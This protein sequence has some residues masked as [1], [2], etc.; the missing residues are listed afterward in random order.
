M[1]LTFTAFGETVEGEIESAVQRCRQ[2]LAFDE[3]DMPIRCGITRHAH[4]IDPWDCGHDNAEG[5]IVARMDN[6]SP[7]EVTFTL[8]A[9]WS[10]ML[11]GMGL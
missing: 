9:R 2:V 4:R 11:I 3:D 10:P 1:R 7:A 5:V 6:G 8:D